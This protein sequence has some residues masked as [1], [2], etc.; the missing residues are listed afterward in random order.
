MLDQSGRCNLQLSGGE[1]TVR[2]DLSDV[3]A[4]GK[5]KGFPYLQ[6]NTNGL[7]LAAQGDYAAQLKDAGL[8]CVFLQFDAVEDA[9]YTALRGRPLRAE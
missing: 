6:L 1:P 3:I 4:L 8:D 7:R 9:A 5:A 2:D